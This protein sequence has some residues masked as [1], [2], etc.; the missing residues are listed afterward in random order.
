MATLLISL[1]VVSNVN[2]NSGFLAVSTDFN[3][4]NFADTWNAVDKAVQEL[5]TAGRYS[6]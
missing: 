1:S 3:N 2:A 6:R 4:P 5:L